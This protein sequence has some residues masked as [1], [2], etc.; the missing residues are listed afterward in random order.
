MKIQRKYTTRGFVI[1]LKHLKSQ[2]LLLISAKYLTKK[3]CI[4]IL[5]HFQS[6]RNMVSNKEEFEETK[7]A[8]INRISNCIFSSTRRYKTFSRALSNHSV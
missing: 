6:D 2:A 1:C 5:I 8:I 3:P 7:G 4:A